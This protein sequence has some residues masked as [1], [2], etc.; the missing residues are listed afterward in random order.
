MDWVGIELATSRPRQHWQ[1]V[2]NAQL[3]ISTLHAFT[4][5]RTFTHLYTLWNF[6]WYWMQNY[7]VIFLDIKF[8]Y[9]EH[10]MNSK[11]FGCFHYMSCNLGR[12]ISLNQSRAKGGSNYFLESDWSGIFHTYQDGPI[13][14]RGQFWPRVL[15]LPASVCVCVHLSVSQ[16]SLEVQLLCWKIGCFIG[17]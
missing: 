11:Y 5:V 7:F 8:C 12:H 1:P 10:S 13:F 16:L 2:W 17:R 15:S 9:F 3:L 4:I 6:I 14:T